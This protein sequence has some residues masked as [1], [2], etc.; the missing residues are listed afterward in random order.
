M[1]RMKYRN[2]LSL[3]ILY[4]LLNFVNSNKNNLGDNNDMIAVKFING[5]STYYVFINN[6]LNE[7]FKYRKDYDICD[8]SPKQIFY[9]FP[10]SLTTKYNIEGEVKK[11]VVRSENKNIKNNFSYH[12]YYESHENPKGDKNLTELIIQHSCVK[13][14]SE[15]ETWGII[16][17]E[18][19]KS[20]ETMERIEFEFLKFCEPPEVLGS[21]LT[22]FLLFL[23]ATFIVFVSTY[24]EITLELRDIKPEGE[25]KQWHGLLLVFTGSL[26]LILIFYF[27]EY[28]NIFMTGLISFQI[29]L[30]LYLCLKT[31]YEFFGFTNY[32][33][34][35]KF[36]HRVYLSSTFWIEI[37]S[38]FLSLTSAVVVLIYLMTRHWILNNIFGLCLVFTILSIFHIRSFKICA[39]LLLSAFIYDVFWV[40]FSSFFFAQNVMV[41]AATS[42]NLPIKLEIPIFFGNHPLKSCMF[43][44]LGDLVLP[45]LVLKFCNRF[46]FIKNTRVYFLASLLIYFLALLLSGAVLA[47]F[48][49]PQPV[50][51]YI[52]PLLLIGI[53]FISY[54]RKELDIWHADLLEDNLSIFH[55]GES[56]NFDKPKVYQ[57]EISDKDND[58][59]HKQDFSFVESVYSNSSDEK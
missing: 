7:L 28:M 37:Y 59:G 25:I 41:V 14:F 42:L 10:D 58:L 45:G 8:C 15:E 22:I 48:K 36:N 39:I 32:P 13:E 20:L 31:L 56:D 55:T 2:I 19:Y 27:I 33:K 11:I 35:S 23:M 43:L 6:T 50:L 53:S 54:K 9:E 18:L 26:V 21:Y 1:I 44:G 49:Y 38:L 46:D 5:N 29:G 30:A 51:F 47:I 12:E 3:F 34:F 40:Y 17:V 24:S 4:F 16:K 57:I 52:S